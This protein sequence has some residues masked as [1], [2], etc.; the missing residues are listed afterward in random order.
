MAVPYESLGPEISQDYH[1]RTTL[2]G[3]RDGLLIA[4]TLAAAASPT[5][6]KALFGL[7]DSPEDE[8][9]VFLRLAVFYAPFLIAVSWTCVLAIQESP[10]SVTGSSSGIWNDLRY[11]ARNKPFMILLVSYTIA[12]FGSNLPAT[13]ILY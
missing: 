3:L 9:A 4:G 1:E 11:V 12:A 5:L 2:F 6:V 13:L 10:A 7:S 8:R